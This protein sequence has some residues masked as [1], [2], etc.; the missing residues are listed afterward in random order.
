MVL[1]TLM[2]KVVAGLAG[3]VAVAVVVLATNPALA[4]ASFKTTDHP[5]VVA[6]NAATLRHVPAGGSTVFCGK[7]DISAITPDISFTGAPV[8]DH[9]VEEVVAPPSAGTIR[10]TS[11]HNVDGDVTPLK[12][13]TGS[14][15]W[16]NTYAV[17]SF[18]GSE[19]HGTLPAGKYTF[20]VLLAGKPIASTSI[21]LVYRSAC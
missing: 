17:M 16:D 21:R 10:I 8:G 3:S 4:A 20:E 2:H 13:T 7:Q 15:A 5:W 18:P 9:Y 1:P 12:F 11:L 19:G 6:I 14:G